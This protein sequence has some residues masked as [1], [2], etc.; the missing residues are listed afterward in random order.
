MPNSVR[1]LVTPEPR[2]HLPELRRLRPVPGRRR[3]PEH[4]RRPGRVRG[5]LSP[6]GDFA[7]NLV[8]DRGVRL[9]RPR[10]PHVLRPD[11]PAWLASACHVPCP[12]VVTACGQ[13]EVVRIPPHPLCGRYSVPLKKLGVLDIVLLLRLL[14]SAW[15]GSSCTSTTR[16]RERPARSRTRSASSWPSSNG[17][18]GAGRRA[19]GGRAGRC[20]LE[21]PRRRPVRDDPDLRPVRARHRDA[22]RAAERR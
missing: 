15:P 14:R 4:Q 11:Q 7:A 13:I 18:T 20:D 17:W 2:E 10:D 22:A 6:L 3:L 12:G 9:E 8:L 1:L 16:D 21:G 19:P 5:P